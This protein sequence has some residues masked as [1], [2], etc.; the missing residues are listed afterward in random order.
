M[1][2]TMDGDDL[3]TQISKTSTAVIL[4]QIF[5]NIIWLGKHIRIHQI[6]KIVLI[7]SYIKW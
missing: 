5:D 3:V 4:T 1:V 6:H 2:D 7:E